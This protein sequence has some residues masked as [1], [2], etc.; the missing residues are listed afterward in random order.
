MVATFSL[1]VCTLSYAHTCVWK[2]TFPWVW[3]AYVQYMHEHASECVH[4]C[5]WIVYVLLCKHVLFFIIYQSNMIGCCLFRFLYWIIEITTFKGIILELKIW[6]LHWRIDTTCPVW[7]INIKSDCVFKWT[8]HLEIVSNWLCF[9]PALPD[10]SSGR[11]H[12][13]CP[14]GLASHLQRH[15]RHA[16]QH[17]HPGHPQ[18]FLGGVTSLE[19]ADSPRCHIMSLWNSFFSPASWKGNQQQKHKLSMTEAL[20][21]WDVAVWH[22]P[23]Q[24]E[25]ERRRWRRGDGLCSR[26]VSWTNVRWD[27]FCLYL[28]RLDWSFPP[29][30]VHVG[31]FIMHVVTS[32][33]PPLQKCL[34]LFF[35][36][37]WC[38]TLCFCMY[39]IPLL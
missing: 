27:G 14:P 29:R 6:K 11:W 1:H 5:I 22:F 12:E 37:C 18:L 38:F 8:L 10:Q 13:E 31:T 28:R 17:H 20:D 35:K 4:Q 21:L 32:H 16:N 25:R 19:L 9:S 15:Q 3:T 33:P 24:Q 34:F 2:H 36:F 7:I 26:L 39:S 30:D 23:E